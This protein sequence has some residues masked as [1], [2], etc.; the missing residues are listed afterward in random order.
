[1]RVRVA[2]HSGQSLWGWQC[3]IRSGKQGEEGNRWTRGQPSWDA[4]RVCVWLS[5]ARQEAGEHTQRTCVGPREVWSG[6]EGGGF[7]S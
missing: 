7:E 1:M 5:A 6:R 2:A 4:G 3:S